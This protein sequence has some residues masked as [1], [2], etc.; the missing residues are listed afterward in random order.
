MQ[1]SIGKGTEKND[2][3]IIVESTYVSW[4]KSNY[5]FYSWGLI[6][7]NYPVWRVLNEGYYRGFKHVRIRLKLFRLTCYISLIHLAKIR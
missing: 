7:F 3:I 4:V 6:N 5:T 2:V 1:Q